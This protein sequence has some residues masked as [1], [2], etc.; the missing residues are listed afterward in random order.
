MGIDAASFWKRVNNLIKSQGTKQ[1]TLAAECNI[2]YQTFRGWVSRK[3]FPGGDETY[4]IAQALNTS[5]EY[6]VSGDEPKAQ[7]AAEE[8]LY[9]IQRVINDYNGVQP[10]GCPSKKPASAEPEPPKE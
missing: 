9:K 10:P 1:E 8:A 2:S 6:L 3:T 5:V 4:Q 7:S